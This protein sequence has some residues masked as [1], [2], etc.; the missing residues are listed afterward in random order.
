M[1]ILTRLLRIARAE[2]SYVAKKA[3]E[4]AGRKHAEP[5]EAQGDP[6]LRDDPAPGARRAAPDRSG[7]RPRTERPR[8]REPRLRQDPVLASHYAALKLPY[9]APMDEVRS[10]YH[11]AMRAYHP[12][13]HAQ[14]PRRQAQANE[15]AQRISEAYQAL[16]KH[17]E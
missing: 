6:M 15:V 16:K 9:G 8:D 13:R 3:Q 12:D 2:A 4:L 17:L 1:S 10:A 5:I 7:Q 14:D 11:K